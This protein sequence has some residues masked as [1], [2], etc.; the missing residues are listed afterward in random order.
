MI[1]GEEDSVSEAFDTHSTRG[2]SANA[3]HTN[4]PVVSFDSPQV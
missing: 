3:P 4:S 2:E 1:E